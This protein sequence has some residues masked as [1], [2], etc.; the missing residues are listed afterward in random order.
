MQ[1]LKI[2]NQVCKE[3]GVVLRSLTRVASQ[4]FTAALVVSTQHPHSSVHKPTYHRTWKALP[5]T[6]LLR[7]QTITHT[8]KHICTHMYIQT[9]MH[10]HICTHAYTYPHVHAYMHTHLCTHMYTCT[11]IHMYT[12]TH[13]THIHIHTNIYICIHTCID[14]YAHTCLY[15]PVF[16]KI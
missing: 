9:H 3:S 1:Y 15:I 11:H 6:L 12:Y 5:Q 13:N 4:N 2:K 14:I 8:H 10:A 7:F 16:I